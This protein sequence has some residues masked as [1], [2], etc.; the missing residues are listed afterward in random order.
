MR[1]QTTILAALLLLS[2]CVT[3]PKDPYLAALA[4]RSGISGHR[5]QTKCMNKLGNCLLLP[6]YRSATFF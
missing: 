2:D 5:T 3:R 6:R 4:P 1:R